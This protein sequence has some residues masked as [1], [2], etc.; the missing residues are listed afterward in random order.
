MTGKMLRMNADGSVPSD[1][2]S[3]GSL[4]YAWGIRN[5]FGFDFDPSNN[6]LIATMEGPSSDDKILIIIYDLPARPAGNAGNATDTTLVILF[7]VAIIAV[8]VLMLYTGLRYR[9][10]VMRMRGRTDRETSS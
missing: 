7:I 6:R 5:S 10:R 2:P 9:R 8:G 4:D 1:N 3:P